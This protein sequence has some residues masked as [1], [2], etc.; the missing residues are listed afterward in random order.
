MERRGHSGNAGGVSGKVEETQERGFHRE[1]GKMGGFQKKSGHRL[2]R[3]RTT[4]CQF[5]LAASPCDIV[6]AA[7]E[8]Y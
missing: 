7:L 2:S 3:V 8:E 5:D 6:I 1:T 4:R